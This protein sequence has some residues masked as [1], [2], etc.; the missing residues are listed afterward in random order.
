[1]KI[2]DDL[3]DLPANG[4]SSA[5]HTAADNGSGVEESLSSHPLSGVGDMIIKQEDSS[6]SEE[7]EEEEAKPDGMSVWDIRVKGLTTDT[8]TIFYSTFLLD[9][10]SLAGF[11]LKSNGEIFCLALRV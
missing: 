7:E 9:P 10:F 5:H 4:V 2:E 8:H 1:M 6:E 11:F 3:D